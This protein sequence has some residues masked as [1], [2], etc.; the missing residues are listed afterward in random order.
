M[1]R[2]STEER[3]AALIAL[4]RRIFSTRPYDAISTD[5]IAREAGISKGLLYHYFPGKREFYVATVTSLADELLAILPFEIAS[6]DPSGILLTTRETLQNFISFIQ[7]NDALY[8]TL[9]RG[10]IG[11]DPE[12]HRIV[13]RVRRTV[14][15]RVRR[16]LGRAPEPLMDLR[17]YGWLGFVE[18]TSLEWLEGRTASS[19]DAP[20]GD[21]VLTAGA[22]QQMWVSELLH[23]LSAGA[24]DQQADSL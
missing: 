19:E 21:E 23:H 8:R 1:A 14:L 3:R 24:P 12:V 20:P 16:L 5:E 9:L 10:G 17:L 11:M 22:L 15:E 6:A 2:Q 4:G 7:Q 18:H 13:E